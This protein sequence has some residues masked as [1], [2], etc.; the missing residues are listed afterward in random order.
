M[1]GGG[2]MFLP[3]QYP[4]IPLSSLGHVVP[5]PVLGMSV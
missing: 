2:L 3:A 4:A 1:T 5:H